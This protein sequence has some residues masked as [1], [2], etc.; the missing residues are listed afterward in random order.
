M[1]ENVAAEAS[2]KDPLKTVADAM[3]TA[4]QA[5]KHGAADAKAAVEDALPAISQFMSRLVYTTC[6][7]V[8]Y[9]VV[10]P[11]LLLARAVPKDNAFVHGLVDG[12]QA[13]MDMVEDWKGR[14]STTE[15]SPPALTTH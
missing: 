2:A 8:S 5:A 14:Q 10:F 13:A 12:A 6:Y 11:S 1:T 4:V 9:G 7:S 15:S 3:D